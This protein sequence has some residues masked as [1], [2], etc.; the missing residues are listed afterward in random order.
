MTRPNWKPDAAPTYHRDGTVSYWDVYL[1]QWARQ[2]A[3]EIRDEVQ[4]SQCD[5][6]RRRVASMAIQYRGTCAE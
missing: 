4:A 1:Q 6:F 5:V 2:P 3:H